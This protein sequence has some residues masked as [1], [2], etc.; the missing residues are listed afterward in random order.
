MTNFKK[1]IFAAITS[2]ALLANVTGSAFAATTSVEI[3]GNGRDSV[4]D[5]TVSNSSTT[6]VVQNN[7]ADVNNNIQVNS[8]TGGN[9]ANDN[10]GEV[11]VRSGDAVTDVTV[12]NDLNRNTA[13]LDCCTTGGT[14]VKI[15]G[16][17]RDSDN[18]VTL[19]QDNS[20]NAFQTNVASVTNN[21]DVDAKT[22]NNHA[23]DNLGG[24]VDVRSGAT[25]TVIGLFT[26]ANDNKLLVGGGNSAGAGDVSALVMG[27]GRNSTNDID[28][29]MTR[30]L[31]VLQSNYAVVTNSVDVDAVTGKNHANDNS[32]E[33]MIRS[34][35][36]LTGVLVDNMVNFNAAAV[37]CGCLL[38]NV[39]AKISDNLRDSENDITLTLDDSRE[40]FQTNLSDLNNDLYVDGKTGN[41]H[42]NDN[43]SGDTDPA[44]H[45]GHAISEFEVR[46]TGNTNTFGT[47]FAMP[48]TGSQVNLT[49]NWAS[50][51]AAFGMS[52]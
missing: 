14:N 17:L 6:S 49:W 51:M 50:M 34:G 45:S 42:A 12:V 24:S 31:N 29:S 10:S 20:K 25:E 35:H 40:V 26:K 22:G 3:S 15:G 36:A 13:R 38:G 4:N 5:A 41:N 47:S 37:D 33:V 11:Y 30:D 16:N 23:N 39:S 52:M 21:V 28:L 2:V 27:N 8:N 48:G 19:S 18:S 9:R 44:I 43:L 1:Q 7:I 46:N 32:G